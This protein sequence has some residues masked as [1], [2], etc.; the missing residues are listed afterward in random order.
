MQG[1]CVVSKY[2]KGDAAKDTGA[3]IK[4][5]SGAWHAARDDAASSGHLPERNSYKT[6]D[7]PEGSALSGIF[8]RVF[9]RDRSGYSERGSSDSEDSKFGS[10]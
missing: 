9:G 2:G 4:D 6:S 8:D 7:S 10:D 3:S 1:E 5:T